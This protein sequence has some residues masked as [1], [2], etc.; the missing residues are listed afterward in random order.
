MSL[1][2]MHGQ[3]YASKDGFPR[4]FSRNH[5]DLGYAKT[6]NL[7]DILAVHELVTCNAVQNHAEY[8]RFVSVFREM[9]IPNP[10]KL[11]MDLFIFLFINHWPRMISQEKTQPRYRAKG[12]IH[13]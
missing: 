7:F 8:L 13:G 9:V 4:T 12:F 11:G 3:F 2:E 1:V 6:L 10:I 5:E